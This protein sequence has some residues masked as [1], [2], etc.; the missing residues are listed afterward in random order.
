MEVGATRTAVAGGGNSGSD[1]QRLTDCLPLWCI[2]VLCCV[3]PTCCAYRHKIKSRSTAQ[4]QTIWIGGKR[5][6]LLW[7]VL[8]GS[9]PQSRGDE[10]L[11]QTHRTSIWNYRDSNTGTYL[12]SEQNRTDHEVLCAT[13]HSSYSNIRTLIYLFKIASQLLLDDYYSSH[14]FYF[15][16]SQ[17]LY[18]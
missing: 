17:V 2:L 18:F 14:F 3:I 13:S 16:V 4:Q 1:R 15:Y 5:I 6:C 8:E 7:R 11:L 10:E 9:T 12:E